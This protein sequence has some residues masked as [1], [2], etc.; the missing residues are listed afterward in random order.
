MK[1]LFKIGGLPAERAGNVGNDLTD[2]Y[3]KMLNGDQR[4]WIQEMIKPDVGDTSWFNKRYK[5]EYESTWAKEASTSIDQR[6]MEMSKL[7][8]Q[9]QQLEYKIYERELE[10]R[11][12]EFLRKSEPAL[13]EAWEQYKIVRKLIK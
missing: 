7:K 4:A 2:S 6:G 3:D 1:D 9:I 5:S 11:K 13:K 10:D 12:E 8:L